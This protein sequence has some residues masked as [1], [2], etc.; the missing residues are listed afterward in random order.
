MAHDGGPAR[1]P[2]DPLD[3]IDSRARLSSRPRLNRAT[4]GSD[5]RVPSHGRASENEDVTA[6]SGDGRVLDGDGQSGHGQERLAVGGGQHVPVSRRPV[7][8]P[9]DIGRGA[10]RDRARPGARLGQRRRG[11]GRPHRGRSHR[12]TGRCR[13]GLHHGS[14][15][16]AVTAEDHV[17]TCQDGA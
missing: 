15:G 3:V 5:G 6:H 2:V 4:G 13:E 1:A 8:A 17:P 10:D 12:G 14:G 9:D 16:S 11:C 7:G